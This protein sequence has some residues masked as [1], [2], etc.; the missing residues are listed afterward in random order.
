MISLS[1]FFQEPNESLK[2]FLK[3]FNIAITKVSNPKDDMIFIALV[4][5]IHPDT[6]VGKWIEMQQ[7]TTIEEFHRRVN[8][9]LRL[10]EASM[11]EGKIIDQQPKEM[12]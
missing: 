4:R 7:P 8:W 12:V 10:D 3:W 6:D 11:I 1:S 2:S 5:T 9:F